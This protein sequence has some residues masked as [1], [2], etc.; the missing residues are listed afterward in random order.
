VDVFG[1]SNTFHCSSDVFA[2]NVTSSG[3]GTFLGDKKH[4]TLFGKLP[5]SRMTFQ[6]STKAFHIFRKESLQKM[7]RCGKK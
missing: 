5:N 3:R 7:G 1:P 4:A 2:Q 6:I